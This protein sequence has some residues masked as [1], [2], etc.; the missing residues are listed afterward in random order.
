LGDFDENELEKAIKESMK[1]A[2]GGNGEKG[3]E[4]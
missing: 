1:L 4:E 2:E 3:V